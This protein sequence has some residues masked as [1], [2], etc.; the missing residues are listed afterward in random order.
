MY[1]YSFIGLYLQ[2]DSVFL[3]RTGFFEEDIRDIF[4]FYDYLRMLLGH[5]FSGSQINRDSEE[6]PAIDAHPHRHERLGPA[7]WSDVF[8]SEISMVLSEYYMLVDGFRKS[9]IP[10]N[11]QLL[12]LDASGIESGWRIHDYQ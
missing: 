11:L 9:D 6:V 1:I 2:D 4:E 7:R 3:D 10:E 12:L 8:F 5:G